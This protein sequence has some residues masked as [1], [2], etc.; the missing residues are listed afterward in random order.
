MNPFTSKPPDAGSRLT[1]GDRV[2]AR[3]LTTI[4]AGTVTVPAPDGVTH[5]QLRRFASCPICNVHL[6][7]FAR[8]HDEIVSAG[9]HEVVVFH[10]PAEAM[11]PHQGELPFAAIADP[12]LQLYSEFKV[13]FSLRSVLDPRAWTAPFKPY[14]WSVAMRERRDPGGEWFGIRGDRMLGHPAEF[15]IDPDGQVLAAKYGRHAND[16]WSVDQLLRTV[17]AIA[18]G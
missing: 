18:A 9:V 14:A 7:S 12:S 16:Q 13:E 11:L 10:S 3:A 1:Q 5:L 2:C 17:R 4:Q 8:R 6:R 15:L